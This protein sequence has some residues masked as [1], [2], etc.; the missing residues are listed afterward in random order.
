MVGPGFPRGRVPNI[1]VKSYYIWHFFPENYMK[2]KMKL[3]PVSLVPLDPRFEHFFVFINV[4]LHTGTGWRGEGSVSIIINILCNKTMTLIQLLI[5]TMC[6]VFHYATL[7][8]PIGG[9][10]GWRQGRAPPPL[11]VQILSF[12]CSFQQIIRKII[13]FWELAPLPGE[14]SG[15]ATVFQIYEGIKTYFSIFF[16]KIA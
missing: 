8:F 12:S 16:I 13:D 10:R 1:D 15:S 14:S 3:G 9:S 11:R 2:M 4:F 5:N 7:R 6:Y